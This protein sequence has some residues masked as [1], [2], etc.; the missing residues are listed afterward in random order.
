[1]IS[2]NWIPD[3]K[4]LVAWTAVGLCVFLFC[5]IAMFPFGALQKRLLVELTR[6]TGIDAQVGDWS[7][8]WPLG[9]E[10]RHVTLAKSDW[11]PV[12]LALLQANVGIAKALGGDFALDIVARLDEAS[13]IS[14]LVNASVAVSSFSHE[15]PISVDGLLRDIDLPKILHRYVSRGVLN[16]TFSHRLDSGRQGDGVLRGEG[17]WKAD[18]TDLH[19]DHIL[20][21]NGK[22]LSLT[23]ETVSAGLTCRD[24]VCDVT[25]F[26]G[27]GHDGAFTG[28]GTI[29]VHNPIVNS[30]LALTMTLVPGVGFAS[31]APN[32]GLPPLP[33]GSPIKLKIVGPLAQP[34]IAL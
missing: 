12:Q 15:G 17:T 16:G 32:L 3:R 34:R 20:L 19:I 5:L 27:D 9:I 23:F 21:G 33:V 26:R 25:E 2:V 31:K 6:A 29:T 4:K 24:A 13:S 11:V 18:A 10:W 22:T 8:A 28:E 7:A 1:M 14:G 30:Q